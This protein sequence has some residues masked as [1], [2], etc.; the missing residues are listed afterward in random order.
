MIIEVSK[1]QDW[2]TH[3]LPK[4]DHNQ[5]QIVKKHSD[6]TTHML[7]KPDQNQNQ[8]VKKNTWDWTTVRN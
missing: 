6:W 3:I 4:W 7:P 2:T 1:A 8:I 5:N